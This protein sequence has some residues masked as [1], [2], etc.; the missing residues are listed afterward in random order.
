MKLTENAEKYAKQHLQPVR[1]C[2]INKRVTVCNAV[3][4]VNLCSAPGSARRIVGRG[5]RQNAGKYA[6]SSDRQQ[7]R[8]G[9]VPRLF[10]YFPNKSAC[11]P[12]RARYSSFPATR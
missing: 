8:P 12:V 2:W 9:S 6:E 4:A 3:Q 11:V 10:A 5:A 1:I 7:V